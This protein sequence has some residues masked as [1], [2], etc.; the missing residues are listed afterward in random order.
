MTQVWLYTFMIFLKLVVMLFVSG[1]RT[2]KRKHSAGGKSEFLC[3]R[4][5]KL[6]N[7]VCLSSDSDMSNDEK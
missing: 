3:S 7:R 5:Y 6:Q 4:L 1:T 2:W